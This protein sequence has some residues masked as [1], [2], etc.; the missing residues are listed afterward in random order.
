MLGQSGARWPHARRQRVGLCD[1]AAH[2]DRDSD[3]AQCERHRGDI[4]SG[5]SGATSRTVTVLVSA[6]AL[7]DARA[8]LKLVAGNE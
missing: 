1:R 4:R 3:G 6:A 5:L 7:K 8:T 2:G